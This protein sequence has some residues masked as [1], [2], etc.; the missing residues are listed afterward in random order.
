MR[1]LHEIRKNGW[2]STI[3]AIVIL[4][5]HLHAIWQLPENDA[6][7]ATRWRL[8]KSTF[9]RALPTTEAIS[10]SRKKKS[11]RGIWQRRYWEHLIR[12]D[13]GYERHVDYP[14]LIR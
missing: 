4:P 12:D 1:F 2:L 10:K 11:E 13:K 3:D 5:D 8:I 6:D 9:S 14:I 7:F